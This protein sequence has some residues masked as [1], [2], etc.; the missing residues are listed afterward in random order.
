MTTPFP[1]GVALFPPPV[2]NVLESIQRAERAGIPMAWI[3]S[4]PV[5]PDGMSIVTAAAVQTNRIGLGTGIALTYPCHP[6]TRVN[7]ALVLAEL[8]PQRFRLGVG[9]SHRPAIEGHYGLPFEKPLTHIREYL[10]VLRGLLWEGRIDLDGSYY[11]VHATLPP[12]I[13][14]P[15]FPL[16]LAALRR[17][18]LRL[19]GEVSD[20]AM[21]IW[22]PLSYV[23]SIALPALEEGA[24]LAQR[25]R[26]PLIVSAPIVLT[27]DF[28]TV[29]K[30]AQAAFA[31]YASF[32]SYGKMFKEAGY[33]LTG[34]GQ[35]TDA[36]IHELFVYGDE[37]TIRQ[38]LFA[39]RDAGVDEIVAVIR[40]LSDPLREE[41]TIF[42]ILANL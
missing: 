39:L 18:M 13:A 12:T 29:R 20:G 7:E 24:R 19:A 32:P 37:E 3:P 34:D 6:L 10:A 23:R 11:R 25:S 8:A 35:L 22:A 9:A 1:V 40:P 41:T 5:G 2:R 27:E 30:V 14:P 4:W 28:A 26:P 17:N 16:I 15:R 38:R 33:P 21:L 36:L 42:E 31:V